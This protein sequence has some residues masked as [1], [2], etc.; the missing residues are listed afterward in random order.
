MQKSWGIIADI[1]DTLLETNTSSIF[2]LLINTFI[3]HP[4]R[5]ASMPEAFS[6]MDKC[7]S[8]PSFWY[9]SASPYN[10]FPY[11]RSAPDITAYL[12][13]HLI[14]PG[15]SFLLHFM[16]RSM[17]F[18]KALGSPPLYLGAVLRPNRLVVEEHGCL[19]FSTGS[20]PPFRTSRHEATIKSLSLCMRRSCIIVFLVAPI[21]PRG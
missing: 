6:Y 10:I 20:S 4:R 5:I 7:L 15:M 21:G 3:F 14:L 2:S 9:I 1:D 16:L 13:G 8:K 19:C 11:L 12:K 18:E 17:G